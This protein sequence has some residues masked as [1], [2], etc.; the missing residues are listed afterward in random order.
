[1]KTGKMAGEPCSE[2]RFFFPVKSAVFLACEILMSSPIY[3]LKK[4]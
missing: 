2:A 1:M 3:F 4:K